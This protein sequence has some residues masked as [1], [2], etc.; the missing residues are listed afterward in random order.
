MMVR[1]G[2]ELL[3]KE[4]YMFFLGKTKRNQRLKFPLPYILR[5]SPTVTKL[6]LVL[7]LKA[8]NPRM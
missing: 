7:T 6:L 4:N 2:K 8:P 5:L 3:K 1:L